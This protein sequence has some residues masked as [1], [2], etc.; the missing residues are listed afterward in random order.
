MQ[1]TYLKLE[2]EKKR[3]QFIKI[4]WIVRYGPKF[5]LKEMVNMRDPIVGLINPK[6][7]RP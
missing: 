3:I 1:G 7:L 4:N 2:K 5:N 6:T